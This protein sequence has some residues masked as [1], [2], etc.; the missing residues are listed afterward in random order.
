MIAFWPVREAALLILKYAAAATICC[1]TFEVNAADV[2][3]GDYKAPRNEEFKSFNELYLTGVMEGFLT[4]NAKLG[5]DG[6][7]KL[8]CLPPKEEVRAQKA[9]EIM[10]HQAKSVPDADN[11]PISILLLAGLIDNFPCEEQTKK[12]L[13]HARSE[14]GKHI[15]YR[16][17]PT[18][19]T[20]ELHRRA[21]S[22]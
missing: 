3:L 17:K 19:A 12:G 9:A 8:F 16:V 14:Q 2:L 5:L 21:K 1:L 6:K 11:Y 15:K 18:Q 13:A 22:S 4:S 10:M 7:P 20:P